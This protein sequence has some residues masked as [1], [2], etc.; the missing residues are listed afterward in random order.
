[1]SSK[2]TNRMIHQVGN[3]LRWTLEIHKQGLMLQVCWKNLACQWKAF[4]HFSL[5][6]N[7]FIWPV[8]IH[9]LCLFAQYL[10]YTFHSVQAV[11]NYVAGVCKIHVLM[12]AEPPSLRHI[13]GQLT[14]LGLKKKM[15]SKPQQAHLINPDILLD[16]VIYLDLTK[17]HDLMFWGILVL[18]FFIFFR[19]SNLIPLSAF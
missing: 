8:P 16:L 11:K 19:K 7:I 15:K 18:G 2:M 12:Q 13:E 4:R 6:Y 5:K 3:N 1:M 17:R 10:S 14:F 9:V